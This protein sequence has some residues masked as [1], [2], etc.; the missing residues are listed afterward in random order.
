[1]VVRQ[2]EELQEIISREAA[3][4]DIDAD[5]L[6]AISIQEGGKNGAVVNRLP[7]KI[8]LDTATKNGSRKY[9]YG[10]MQI[11]HARAVDALK[12]NG[13]DPD[14]VLGPL[15]P[16]NPHDLLQDPTTLTNE[17]ENIRIAAMAVAQHRQQCGRGD[18]PES[19]ACLAAGYNAAAPIRQKEQQQPLYQPEV[20]Q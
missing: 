10:L 8:H 19:A 13:E 7:D 5:L 1:M 3:A 11:Q 6:E 14:V 17:E 16:G 2:S 18:T 15:E 4:N 9:S 20:C 12:A